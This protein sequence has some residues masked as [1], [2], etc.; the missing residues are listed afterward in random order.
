MHLHCY[1]CQYIAES[2]ARTTTH[3]CWHFKGMLL[4]PL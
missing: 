4:L 1:D 3:N 2:T